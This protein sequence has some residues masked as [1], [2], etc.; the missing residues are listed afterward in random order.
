MIYSASPYSAVPY[1]AQ[2]WI[3]FYPFDEEGL[4]YQVV[5]RW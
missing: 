2:P 5:W 1:G 3:F 4:C